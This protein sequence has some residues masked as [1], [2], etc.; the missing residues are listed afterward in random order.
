MG[1]GEAACAGTGRA[2]SYANT[3]TWRRDVLRRA[4]ILLPLI[5]LALAACLRLASNCTA[6]ES[7]TQNTFA[8]GAMFVVGY[9]SNVKIAVRGADGN[10]LAPGEVFQDERD[11]TQFFAP[12]E[13]GVYQVEVLSGGQVIHTQALTV[14]STAVAAQV[15]LDCR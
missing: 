2:V 11:T 7:S 10:V 3:R 8:G 15:F 1:K 5:G 14:T 12:V 6:M 13:P 4:R 9:T